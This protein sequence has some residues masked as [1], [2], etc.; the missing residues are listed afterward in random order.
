MRW[1][2][3]DVIATYTVLF[4]ASFMCWTFFEVYTRESRSAYVCVDRVGEGLWE[5][6]LLPVCCVAGLVTFVRTVRRLKE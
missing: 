3:F 1:K 6:I 2:L 4:L 5:A